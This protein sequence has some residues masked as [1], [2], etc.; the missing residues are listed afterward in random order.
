MQSFLMSFLIASSQIVLRI[1]DL[2]KRID[3]NLGQDEEVYVWEIHSLL[4]G[5]L[6][7]HILSEMSS[8]LT[9]LCTGVVRLIQIH[10]PPLR[11]GPHLPEVLQN[12]S[13]I[14]IG[15]GHDDCFV[16]LIAVYIT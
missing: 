4:T 9:V 10:S 2:L 6:L 15:K 1:H 13:G 11:T 3:Q 14:L 12:N 8:Y 5:L 16:H 7:Q